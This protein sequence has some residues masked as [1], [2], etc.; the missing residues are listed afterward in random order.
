M[1]KCTRRENDLWKLKSCR[2]NY[3]C[4]TYTIE[5]IS[6][7]LVPR[8]H[9]HVIFGVVSDT[10]TGMTCRIPV[11]GESLSFFFFLAFPTWLRVAFHH[12]TLFIVSFFCIAF[13]LLLLRLCVLQISFCLSVFFL[14]LLI[15][16]VFSLL[17]FL[18][19]VPHMT[20]SVLNTEWSEGLKD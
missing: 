8:L 9:W 13:H 17:N 6:L 14:C 12:T 1:V 3:L 18:V 4:K 11:S 2:F 16:F 7:T 5:N 10:G 19:C 15:F 20:W